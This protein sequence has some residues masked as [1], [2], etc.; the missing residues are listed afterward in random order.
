MIVLT[1]YYIRKLRPAFYS[2]LTRVLYSGRVKIGKNFRTDSIPR[3]LVDKGCLITIGD[4][5]EFRRNIEIRAHNLSTIKI[6]E[7]CRI[8][9]GVRLLS[10]NKSTILIG[11]KTRIG[12][13]AVFNGGA[14]ITVGEKC[15]ISGFVYLQ[16]SMH[17][18]NLQFKSVQDQGY[19]HAPIEL[20]ADCWLG[21]H[22]VIMPGIVL[23]TGA[24]VGSNAV[25]TKNVDKFMVVGGI[26]AKILKERAQ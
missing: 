22:V 18:H 21:T 16:T 5:V 11:K 20:K 10:T 12:L 14:D 23:G 3:I 6:E 26:P 7:N 25:V 2:F 13:N 17:A 24:V 4:N 19:D 15:L 9:R 1:Q 8:D